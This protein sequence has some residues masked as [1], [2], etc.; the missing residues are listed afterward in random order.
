MKSTV[1]TRQRTQASTSLFPGRSTK[2]QAVWRGDTERLH[3]LAMELANQPDA[4]MQER[5]HDLEQWERLQVLDE[6]RHRTAG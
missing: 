2:L 4:V 3:Q 5:L 6:I 1:N